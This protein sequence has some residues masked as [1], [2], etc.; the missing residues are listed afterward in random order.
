MINSDK[1]LRKLQLVNNGTL[2]YG[3][4]CLEFRVEWTIY[5]VRRKSF[6]DFGHVLIYVI[7]DERSNKEPYLQHL[8]NFTAIF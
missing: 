3:S 7:Y 6:I 8:L 1:S 5:R 4:L 2:H